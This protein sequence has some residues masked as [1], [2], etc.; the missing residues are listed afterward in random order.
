MLTGRVVTVIAVTLAIVSVTSIA[1]AKT[2][3]SNGYDVE[4]L[5]NVKRDYLRMWG[6]VEGGQK[7]HRLKVYAHLVNDR[8]DRISYATLD[9]IIKSTH[10]SSSRS[11]FKGQDK[12]GSNRY[13]NGWIVDRLSVKCTGVVPKD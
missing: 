13:K 8:Y 7:C 12:I 9:T 2:F 1:S 5:W 11:V 6:T 10:L 3:V 4:L